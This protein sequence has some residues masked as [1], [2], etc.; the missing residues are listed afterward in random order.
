[1]FERYT[2]RA[3][4]AIFF[5]RYEASQF[6]SAWIEGHHLLLGLLREGWGVFEPFLKSRDR[7][8]AIRKEI[9]ARFPH[10]ASVSTSVDLPLSGEC[11]RAV[12][13]AAEESERLGQNWIGTVHLILGLLREPSGAAAEILGRYGMGLE[14]V[15]VAAAHSQPDRI[16]AGGRMFERYSEKSRRVIF[17][18]RHEA[19]ECGSQKIE[20]QHILLG[21]LREG[22]DALA[23]FLNKPDAAGAVRDE[24]KARFPG[25]E[26]VEARAHLP[27][28][29]PLSH[30]SKRVLAYAAEE[31]ER[32]GSRSIEPLHLLLGLLRERGCV[33]AEILR[34]HGLQLET[35][36]KAEAD[37]LAELLEAETENEALGSAVLALPADRQ[38]AA[39][40][41]LAAL[42]RAKVRIDVASPEDSFTVSFDTMAPTR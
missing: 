41:I 1:M 36:R 11:K 30:E 42:A 2:E 20:T 37:P 17:F 32:M 39:W 31:A 8:I 35:V 25:Q 29:L 13:F 23:P 40:R 14:E 16:G 38:D 18:A 4:R 27:Q 3:R 28:D 34:G 10:G 22:W 7:V 12:T 6:G 9:E 19:S 5:A 33:A 21:L 15:R 24:I 26:A